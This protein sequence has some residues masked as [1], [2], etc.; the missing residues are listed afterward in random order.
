MK[1]YQILAAGLIGLCASVPAMA[2]TTFASFSPLS[3]VANI[4]FTG[5]N[6]GSGTL[7]AL[8]APVTF[9]FLNPTGST[10]VLDVAALFNFSAL[11]SGGIVA[12][13]VGIA[14]VTSGTLNFT[15]LA[16][17]TFNGRTGTNLLTA[18]FT[19]GAVTGLV[20]GS[21]ASFVNSQPPSGV[22]F[23]SDFFNFSNSTARDISIAINAI[24]PLIAA[25]AGGMATFDGTASGTF[26]TD[27]AGGIGSTVPEPASW[28]MMIVGFGL[29]GATARRRARAT[30]IAA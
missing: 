30:A 24:N 16:A 12:G 9:R 10:S 13:G 7:S 5:M 8:G 6:N 18:T 28:A 14:P 15:S 22:V 23:T 27:D 19:G 17:T 1:T 25:G 21:V 2:I 11:T 4:N 3:N 26:G 20:G 29:V